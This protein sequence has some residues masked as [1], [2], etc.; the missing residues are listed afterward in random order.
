[1]QTGNLRCRP[2]LQKLAREKGGREEDDP[3]IVST[4]YNAE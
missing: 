4:G 3:V 2:R 1:M